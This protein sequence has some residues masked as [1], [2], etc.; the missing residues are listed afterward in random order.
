MQHK[1]KYVV[2]IGEVLWDMLPTGKTIGGAPANF[3]YHV[4]QFGI[5]SLIVSA[6]GDDQLGDEI[7]GNFKAI[8][9]DGIIS[10]VAHPTG[11]V[12]VSLNSDGTP[13]YNITQ[14]VAWD[15]TPFYPELELI[16]KETYAVCYGSL[17]QRNEVSRATINTFL[18]M[19][20]TED[21]RYK[22][23]D[24]NLRQDFYSKEIILSSID[25]CNV[26][27]INDEELAKLCELLSPT[28]YN[29]TECCL[30]LI[31]D[32][33]IEIVILT[34]G[35]I[36][37]YVFTAHNTS[38]IKTPHVKVA[39]TV[40]AGD[41]FTAAFTAALLRGKT[42]QEAHQLAVNVSAYTCTQNGAMPR[43]PQSLRNI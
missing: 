24:I 39:D 41:S 5:D 42:I 30:Q 3:A 34:C 25:R 23:F 14:N 38:F 7:I 16:A 6:V 35:A 32:Y 4:S 8:G 40:G 2:G 31:N 28:S 36:G 12:Q 26:L 1:G 29:S 27:K 11:T 13:Q 15:N 37:S 18:D 19:M 10:K 22:I 9:L 21:G 33:N 17:A 43:L 20:P